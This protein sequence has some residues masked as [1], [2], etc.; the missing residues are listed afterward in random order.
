MVRRNFK[1]YKIGI[2][3]IGYVGNV[4]RRY[5]RSLRITP[6]VY[7]K[8]KKMGSL[9]EVNNADVIFIAVPTPY[10]LQKGFD[11][12]Y[13]NAVTKDIM[14]NKII[15]LKSTVLPGTTNRLQSKYP[16]HTFLFN[17]EFLREK[18][19]YSDFI[20]PDRQIIGVTTKR[21]RGIAPLIMN[22]LPK[23]S[24]R[25]IMPSQEAEM[26]KYMV[27]SFLA[28]KVIFANE[29]YDLCKALRINYYNVK[30]GVTKDFR[31][32]DSHLDIFHEGYRGYGGSCF[33]KDINAI[34]R[35]AGSKRVS[36]VLLKKA[37]QINRKLLEKYNLDD[38]YFL[39]FLHRRK[40]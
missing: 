1:K 31:I 16:N 29:F 22:L 14:G 33:P 6:F 20:H 13:V 35:F 30:E 7:D 3:G 12:S 4:L 24:H 9:S 5:F 8:Y 21:S 37:R 32:G 18:S 40:N 36:L 10:N 15:V 39:N 2:I 34:I 26:I 25:K 19:A 23:A 38:N 11:L 28:L 17:P 27:N